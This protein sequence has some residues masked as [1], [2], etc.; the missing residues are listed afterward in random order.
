L[1]G[2]HTASIE[3]KIADSDLISP[4]LAKLKSDISRGPRSAKMHRN[5]IAAVTSSTTGAI[6]WG[7]IPLRSTLRLR[8]TCLRFA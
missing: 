5:K 1:H 4:N 2:L 3:H 8:P 6:L 7:R